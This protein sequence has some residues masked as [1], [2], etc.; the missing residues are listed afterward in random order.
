MTVIWIRKIIMFLAVG[1][2]T[3][4][5]TAVCIR[6]GLGFFFSPLQI[7]TIPPKPISDTTA[8][9]AVT[10]V[11]LPLSI[12]VNS[13]RQAAEKYLPL[14]YTD[15]DEDPTD[16]LI[17]D[18]IIYK[19]KRGEIAMGISG[20]GISFSFPVSGTV[21]IDGKVNLGVVAIDTSAHGDVEGIISGEIAFK[22]L[23][24]WRIEP[25]LQFKVAILKAS[26]PVKR[27]GKISL[28]T[29]LEKKLTS[30][31]K[32]KKKK[33]TA[34][35]MDKNIIRDKVSKIWAKM[36]RAELLNEDPKVWARVIP[37]K[38]GFMSITGHKDEALQTGLRLTLETGLFIKEKPPAVAVTG[39]PSAEILEKI[40][41]NFKLQVPFQIESVTLNRY[42]EKKVIGFPRE[43]AK[44][45]SVTVK[46][47]EVISSGED[48]L[49]AILFA[50]VQHTRLGLNTNCRFYINGTV[51]HNAS[52]NEIRFTSI[53]YDASF[54]RWWVSALHWI[55]SPYLIYE[56]EKRLVLSIG[57]E[58]EKAH[59]K[60]TKEVEKLVIPQ[61]IKAN[62]SVNP[63]RL[64]SPGV[65][66]EGFFGELQLDGSIGATLDFQIT[67]FKKK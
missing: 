7:I 31:I 67:P 23:P 3:L 41:D 32:R 59:E 66:R 28:R 39:L 35:V 1:C 44:N 46:R 56:L 15:V 13:L 18:H 27:L 50:D 19:L 62:L 49:S 17:D 54:S 53:D 8:S 60:L 55:A 25:D 34:K 12:P 24:D 22:I 16:M 51:A 29:F 52:K 57:K 9:P 30:K 61:G 21:K 65:N 33:L 48:Q 58:L 47:A 4:S 64:I 20:N 45:I 2:I 5:L 63:P 11:N 37:L 10:V 43:V 6:T 40:P 26:I 42:I 36:H 14:V 38:V